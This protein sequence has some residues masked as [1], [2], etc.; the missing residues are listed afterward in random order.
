MLSHIKSLPKACLYVLLKRI[1]LKNK[2]AKTTTHPNNK[3][4]KRYVAYTNITFLQILH[5]ACVFLRRL[6]PSPTTSTCWLQSSEVHFVVSYEAT[7]HTLIYMYFYFYVHTWIKLNFIVLL[8]YEDCSPD[9]LWDSV[10]RDWYP[11]RACLKSM[12]FS[13]WETGRDGN[14]WVKFVY[15]YF[16]HKLNTGS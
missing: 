9:P 16:Q 5:A 11:H 2:K 4:K 1:Y 12:W 8:P 14:Y 6:Q 10:Q 13:Q 7:W 3:K 15:Q